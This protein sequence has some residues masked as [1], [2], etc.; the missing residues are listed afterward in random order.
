M[1][2]FAGVDYYQ[3]DELLSEEER[4]IRKSVRDFVDREALPIIEDHHSREAFPTEL[5][6]RMA[7]LGFFGANLAGFGCAGL[8]NIS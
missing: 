8:N 7:A 1:S 4:L 6:P 3:V 5:I 2:S